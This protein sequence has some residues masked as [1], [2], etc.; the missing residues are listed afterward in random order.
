MSVE[1]KNLASFDTSVMGWFAAVEV[2][3]AEAAVGL[4]HEAFE[5]II[6]TGPQYSGDFVANTRVSMTGKPDTT[7][8]EG[9]LPSPGSAFKVGDPQAQSIARAQANWVTPK[10]GKPIFISSTAKHDEFY[11]HK[12]EN[13]E[14]ALRPVNQGAD[15]IYR[16]AR[17]YTQ[18]RYASIGKVQ[19]AA[20]RKTTL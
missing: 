18:H 12:I 8:E 19:L 6:E 14:I 10:L 15:H 3:L 1:V 2:A 20:L 13:G 16:R 11:S 5:Q 17:D 9:P 4:A 7:F